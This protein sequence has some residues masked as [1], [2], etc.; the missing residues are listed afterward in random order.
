MKEVSVLASC[1]NGEDVLER[2]DLCVACG[3]SF[4]LY[5]VSTPHLVWIERQT[6][7]IDASAKL[8]KVGATSPSWP[9]ASSAAASHNE[10][11]VPTSC[12]KHSVQF[13]SALGFP[14]VGGISTWT[15]S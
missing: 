1:G 3:K 13:R 11:T 9:A 14:S 10:S 7:F 4:N 6:I 12:A 5:L 2:L 15:L 8:T